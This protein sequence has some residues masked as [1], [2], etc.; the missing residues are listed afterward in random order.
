MK[1]ASKAN[2]MFKDCLCIK[3][4]FKDVTMGSIFFRFQIKTEI[5]VKAFRNQIP[6]KSDS[7]NCIL[8]MRQPETS[9]A[10]HT[11]VFIV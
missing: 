4:G 3:N 6:T 7:R 11:S 9:T 1:K 5:T 8:D 10:Y 2:K